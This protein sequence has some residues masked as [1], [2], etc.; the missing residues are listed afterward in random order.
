MH[1][2]PRAIAALAT[3]LWTGAVEGIGH[4]AVGYVCVILMAAGCATVIAAIWAIALH[5]HDADRRMMIG[6]VADVT[7][8]PAA[9]RST[10]PLLRIAAPR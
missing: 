10:R 4:V 3:L 1:A 2:L 6:T 9:R 5:L 8:P 7:R